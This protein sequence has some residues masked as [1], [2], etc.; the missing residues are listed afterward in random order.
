MPPRVTAAPA[1]AS[2]SRASLP[3]VT[4]RNTATI[5]VTIAIYDADVASIFFRSHQY[6]T[7]VTTDPAR[8]RYTIARMPSGHAGAAHGSLAARER[9]ARPTAPTPIESAV[10][11]TGSVSWPQRFVATDEIAA[12]VADRTIA[13]IGRSFSVPAP[14]S[15]RKIRRMPAKPS[16]IPASFWRVSLSDP[17]RT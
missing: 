12:H 15:P 11:E 4:P 8:A 6:V 13:S 1:I 16:P 7:N 3:T 5:G 10:K 9:A 14:S 2:G 17:R